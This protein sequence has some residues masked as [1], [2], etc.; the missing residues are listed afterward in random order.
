MKAFAEISW[1]D[2]P[3]I[4]YKRI[5]D[6]ILSN[7]KDYLLKVDEEEYI[8]YLVDKYYPEPLYILTETETVEEPRKSKQ[9]LNDM[10]GREFERDAFLFTAKYNFTGN[11]ELFKVQPN[12]MTMT[13][14]EISVSGS[15]VSF[16]FTI[17]KQDVAEFKRVKSDCYSSAFTNL[18]ALN[19][20]ITELQNNFEHTVR[21]LFLTEKNKYKSENDFFTAINIKVNANTISVFTAP[22]IKKK[23]IPQPTISKTKEFSSAPMMATEM[24]DDILKVIY[25]LGKSMEKKPSTYHNKDEEG[26]R[27]Q[28][29]LVLETRYDSTT[30]TGETF[31]RGGKTDIILKYSNDNSNLFV[32][33]CKFWHGSSEFLKAISQLFDRYLTWRDSK[34]ALILF[35]NNKDFTTVVQTIKTD[36]KKHPYFV[37]ENGNRGES[38]FSFIFHLPQDSNK[39]VY[40]EVIAFH[41]DKW[42][43]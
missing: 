24:Y 10:I 36:I 35:V 41:Y 2:Y 29:L 37:K 7:G 4:F 27:D 16:S 15:V 32:A 3:K 12:P 26:L 5:K 42:Q 20:N 8:K 40:L 28:I 18:P 43:T 9:R 1:L 21:N 39:T 22:T 30:A 25:D 6:E 11:A 13:S 14:Y 38:S 34:A 33:E 19:K 23:I 31:N 17:Y